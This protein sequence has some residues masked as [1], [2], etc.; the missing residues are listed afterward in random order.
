MSKPES[1]RVRLQYC[2]LCT[3][4]EEPWKGKLYLKFKKFSPYYTPQGTIVARYNTIK[5]HIYCRACEHYLN[6]NTIDFL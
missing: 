3:E 6:G 5:R 2:S 1:N 4:V